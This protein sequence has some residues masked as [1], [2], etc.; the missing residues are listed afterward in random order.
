MHVLSGSAGCCVSDNCTEIYLDI[1]PKQSSSALLEARADRDRWNYLVVKNKYRIIF[2]HL[3]THTIDFS[4]AVTRMNVRTASA[5]TRMN[6]RTACAVTRMNV[7]TACAVTRMN[8]RTA[9]PVTRMNVRTA[10]AVTRMNVRTA[11]AVTR[12]NVRTACAV[13]R[14]NIRTACAVTRMNV[15]TACATVPLRP[16][17]QTAAA[18][19]HS[20]Y[21]RHLCC[22]YYQLSAAN[23]R[24]FMK[25]RKAHTHTTWRQ[26]V[27]CCCSKQVYF[28]QLWPLYDRL[29]VFVRF[30]RFLV[31]LL[32]NKC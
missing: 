19:C 4:C 20:E 23:Q 5:V 28:L 8:V 24:P 31:S 13:T 29:R 21:L 7:R 16:S 6:I 32:S 11:C 14:M 10:C 15:R 12:M 25:F 22:G 9:C 1:S 30:S 26:A 18:S 3:D 17:V 27:L 2:K